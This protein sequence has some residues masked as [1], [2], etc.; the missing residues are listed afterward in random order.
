MKW[1]A[2]ERPK[3]DRIACPWLIK[4]FIE[5]C[6]MDKRSASILNIMPQTFNLMD[7]LRLSILP[8]C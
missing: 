8:K 6:R 4:R 2:R 3:I 7:A 1:V 5:V